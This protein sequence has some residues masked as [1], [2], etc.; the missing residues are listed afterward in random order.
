[1]ATNIDLSAR[2][3]EGKKTVGRSISINGV[4]A[5]DL[6]IK[7]SE[8]LSDPR[9]TS[10]LKLTTRRAPLAR[11]QAH[12]EVAEHYYLAPLYDSF[13]GAPY[14]SIRALYPLAG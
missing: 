6:D 8:N 9:S 5:V 7:Q 12:L 4:H 10:I 14:R 11:P 2:A 13:A 1:M 3:S